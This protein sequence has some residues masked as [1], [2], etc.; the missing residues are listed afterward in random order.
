V[1][2]SKVDYVLIHNVGLFAWSPIDMSDIDSN[3]M[4]HKL[5]ILSQVKLVVRRKRKLIEKW[6]MAISKLL[7]VDFIRKIVLITWLANVTMV[8]WS[9]GKWKIYINYMCLKDTYIPPNI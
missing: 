9:N 6:H 4:S 7:K 1:L 5:T 8:K 3:I 2:R